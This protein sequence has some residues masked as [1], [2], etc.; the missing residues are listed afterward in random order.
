MLTAK[1]SQW[2]R[3]NTL[4]L[5]ALQQT[6]RNICSAIVPRNYPG[7]TQVVPRNCYPLPICITD[8]VM[9]VI[10]GS[11]TPQN[12][13]CLDISGCDNPLPG[14]YFRSGKPTLSTPYQATSGF[15]G[16]PTVKFLHSQSHSSAYCKAC[17]IRRSAGCT[18]CWKRSSRD[19][20]WSLDGMIDID[21]IRYKL[22]HITTSDVFSLF[23]F[24]PVHSCHLANEAGT[25]TDWSAMR[26][27]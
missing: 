3:I 18:T 7:S 11:F 24:H 1:L 6:R 17:R 13:S 20:T 25:A 9:L 26:Q 10:N 2:S 22:C 5:Q 15:C 4:N 14:Y 16:S 21:M 12:T 27:Y 19:P 8:I 23:M